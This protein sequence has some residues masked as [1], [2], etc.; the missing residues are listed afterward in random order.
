[1][2][3]DKAP[4]TPAVVVVWG[5]SIAASG[6]PAIAER[7]HNVALNR[8]RPIQVINVGVGGM[9]A[10]RARVQF[11]DVVRPH[12]PV[13]V[14]I[15]F[16]FNDLRYDGSRGPLPISTV[17]EFTEHIAGMVKQCQDELNATVLVFGNHT[18]TRPQTLGT[19]ETL[20]Q[21]SATY[22]HASRVAA[23]RH[24][25]AYLD[26]AAATQSCGARPLDITNE[27][28][29]HLSEYGKHTYGAAAASAIAAVLYKQESQ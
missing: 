25:A 13:I 1:M 18:P 2:S 11:D 5:D 3:E 15:Q 22:N 28:G 20:M 27:D 19:G 6:W 12:Q 7:S 8:G 26:M 10:A 14:I 17:D 16:G 23:E 9:P 24:G 4:A 29:V 21:L